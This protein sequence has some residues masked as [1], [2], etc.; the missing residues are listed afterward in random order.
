MQEHVS[1]QIINLRS[2]RETALATDQIHINVQ[3]SFNR[4]YEVWNDKLKTRL[5]ETILI[6]RAMNP[7]WTVQN[8]EE[9]SEEVLDGMHRLT[10]ALHFLDNV[11]ALSG[12]Y[13]TTL[14]GYNSLFFRD[15]SKSDQH[16]IRNYNFVINKLDASY[17]NDPEKLQDMYD[18]LN[19]SSVMLNEFE[20]NK[21]I[22]NPFYKSIGGFIMQHFRK[23]ALYDSEDNPRGK[24]ESEAMKW[25]ALSE[26]R[27]PVFSSLGDLSEQWQHEHVGRTHADV[28][29]SVLTHATTWL[30]TLDRICKTQAKYV[31]EELLLEGLSSSGLRRNAVPIMFIVTR[32]VALIRDPARVSRHVSNLAA[33][34][35][36]AILGVDI[37]QVLECSSRNAAF[38]RKLLERTDNIILTELGDSQQQPRCFP[39]A[40]IEEKLREQSNTCALCQAPITGSQKYEGDHV[41][42]WI[43]GGNTV[44]SNLQVVHQKC[45]KRK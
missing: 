11:F 40:M 24:L 8:D 14:D 25:L 19:R 36:A 20:Y 2:K 43:K 21:P 5:I 17:K 39:K 41:L 28:V 30:E 33:A 15:L 45:H 35:K 16:K 4:G 38:Q 37:Q 12:T 6:G 32:T 31:D 13:M 10:T 1:L 42:P 9:G 22:Y 34:F 27:L 29:S 23:T 3:P 26:P 44:K 18:I 7:I